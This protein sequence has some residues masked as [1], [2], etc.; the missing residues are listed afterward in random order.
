MSITETLV[1]E[2]IAQAMLAEFETQAPIT[3][4]FLDRSPKTNLPGSRTRNP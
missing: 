3:R 2:S 1:G 4:R